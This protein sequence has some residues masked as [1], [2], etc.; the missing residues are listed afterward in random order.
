M[1]KINASQKRPA[2]RQAGIA[3]VEIL[4]VS[5]ISAVLFGLVTINLLKTQHTAS[6]QS[7]LSTLIS[8]IKSQQN[9]AMAGATEGRN[10][11]DKYGIYFQANK[12]I[13][14][15]GTVFNPNDSSNFTVNL[16]QNITITTAF[17]TS[18]LVFLQMSGEINGFVS[19]QNTITLQNTS[20]NE[21]KIITINRYGVV[22]NIQ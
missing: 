5:A 8:D 2:Y 7:T 1:R 11:A 22:T 17:P 21:Q 16:D 4:L 20:G 9:K 13:L 15:H 12:Y 3:L 6:I 10:T 18:S 14:F 19:G